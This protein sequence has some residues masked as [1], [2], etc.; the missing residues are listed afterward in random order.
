MVIAQVIPNINLSYCGDLHHTESWDATYFSMFLK[1]PSVLKNTMWYSTCN[2][3][4]NYF[5][6]KFSYL[7]RIKNVF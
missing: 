2:F 3:I 4:F 1:V 5:R 6:E 7:N